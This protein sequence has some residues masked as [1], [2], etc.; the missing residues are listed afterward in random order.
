M[1]EYFAIKNKSG[2]FA[3]SYNKKVMKYSELHRLL[4]RYGC[5]DTGEQE[6]GHPIWYSPITDNEFP[7][8]N[9][10]SKE[11]AIGTLKNILKLAG[12]R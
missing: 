4:K 9:H 12:I 3:A 1:H 8:S 10:Q 2:I 6:A 11:V 5:Y 7:T